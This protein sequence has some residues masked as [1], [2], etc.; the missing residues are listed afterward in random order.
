M[1]LPQRLA[2]GSA[3]EGARSGMLAPHGYGPQERCASVPSGLIHVPRPD[4]QGLPTRRLYHAVKSGNL[5]ELQ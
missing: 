4:A 3:R 5:A 2:T 1:R